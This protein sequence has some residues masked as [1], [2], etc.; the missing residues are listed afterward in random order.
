MI[1]VSACL[2]GVNC[3]YDGGNNL[4]SELFEQFKKGKVMPVCPEQLGGLCTPRMPSEIIGGTAKQILEGKDGAKVVRCDGKDITDEFLRGAY[5]TLK[6]AKS[7]QATRA[8]LKA[9]SPS[10]GAGNIYDGSF[11]GKKISGNGIT[12]ELLMKNGIKVYT[13]DNFKADDEGIER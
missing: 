9:S 1:V 11:S 3:K 7:I 13:E 5:E 12:A 2:C 10:C 4:N 6:I 8:I